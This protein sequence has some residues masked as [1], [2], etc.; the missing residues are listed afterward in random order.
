MLL[1]VLPLSARRVLIYNASSAGSTVNVIDSTT[2]KVVQVIQSIELPH[3]V[4]FSADGSRVYISDEAEHM[5][6]VVD[7]K[8]GKTIKKVPLSGIP[9]TL[10]ASQGWKARFCRYP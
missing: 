2:N 1:I 9:N 7:Q 3:D 4:A 10:V 5:L 8:T 6:D